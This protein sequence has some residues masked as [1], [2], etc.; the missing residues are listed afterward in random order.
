MLAADYG[1]NLQIQGVTEESGSVQ[2]VHQS[3]APGQLVARGSIITVEF[4]YRDTIA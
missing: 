1:L 4:V 2:A 3:I